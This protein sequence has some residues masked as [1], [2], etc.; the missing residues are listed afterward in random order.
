MPATPTP[1]PGPR[2]PRPVA[3]VIDYQ[4][5]HLSGHDAFVA[6]RMTRSESCVHPGLLGQALMHRRRAGQLEHGIDDPAELR[7]IEVYRGLPSAEYHPRDHAR[8]V[9]QAAHW[10]TEGAGLTGPTVIV[11]HRDLVYPAVPEQYSIDYQG[12]HRSTIDL[13]LAREKGVDVMCALAVVRLARE[14]GP[15]GVVILA[16]SDRDLAPALDEAMALKHGARIEAMGWDGARGLRTR[17]KLWTTYLNRDEFLG[18]LDDGW[19]KEL[20]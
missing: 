15:R 20:P 10:S 11:Q 4:N 16:S 5:T 17:R 3:L 2:G 8:N 14:L 12:N 19:E 6:G 7:R 18:C 9:A 13:S 1:L